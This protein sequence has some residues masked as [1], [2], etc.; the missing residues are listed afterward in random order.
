M[1][2]LL[3][4]IILLLLV[5]TNLKLFAVSNFAKNSSIISDLIFDQVELSE[6]IVESDPKILRIEF[7]VSNGA[8][9]SF[10]IGFTDDSTD[11]WDYGLDG[12]LIQNPPPDDM[13]SLLDGQQYIIQA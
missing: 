2:N 7:R 5:F 9:R 1:K 6:T 12:G 4:L 10:V 11:G 3:R 8:S 13:G